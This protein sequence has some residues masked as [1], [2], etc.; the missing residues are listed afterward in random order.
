MTYLDV[1]WACNEMKGPGYHRRYD[2]DSCTPDLN[3]QSVI[4]S[5]GYF[6]GLA[7]LYLTMD[8]VLES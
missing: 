5:F 3:Q 6:L 2:S 1:R 4:E 7:V 8:T